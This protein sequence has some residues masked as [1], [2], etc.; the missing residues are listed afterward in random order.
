MVRGLLAAQNSDGG[1]IA[2]AM[3]G[4]MASPVQITNGNRTKIT[5]KYV[6]RLKHVIRQAPAHLPPKRMPGDYYREH[7]RERSRERDNFAGMPSK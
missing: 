6:S 2:D 1:R 4:D 7:C 3:A 5:N